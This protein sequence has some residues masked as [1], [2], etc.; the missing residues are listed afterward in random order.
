MAGLG[1]L[2]GLKSLVLALLFLLPQPPWS[3]VHALVVIRGS[4]VRD[5]GATSKVLPPVGCLCEAG[6]LGCGTLGVYCVT[7]HGGR[8]G[9]EVYW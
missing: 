4:E 9:V 2:A 8:A 6:V 5:E 1:L 7:G 3:H